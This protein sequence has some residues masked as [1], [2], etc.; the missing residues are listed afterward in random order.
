[1]SL[2]LRSLSLTL[3]GLLLLT[4]AAATAQTPIL[5]P[6]A[7]QRITQPIDDS[8]LTRIT[9]SVHPALAS[10]TDLG[11]VSPSLP[12]QR[13]Q[14]VLQRSSERQAAFDA[15]T[16]SQYAPGS[17]NYHHWLSPDQ[18]GSLFGVSDADLATVTTWLQASGFAVTSISN[19]R[20]FVEFS[21]TA[22]Q[23]QQTFHTQIH[24]FSADGEQHIANISDPQI[25]SALTPVVTG[26]L[27]LN[28]FFARSQMIKGPQVQRSASGKVTRVPSAA[29]TSPLYSDGQGDFYI[30]PFDFATIYNS[31]PLWNSGLNGTGVQIAIVGRSDIFPSDIATF[32]STYGLPNNPPTIIHNGPAPGTSSAG[33]LDENTL[34]VEW[35]GAAAPGA[36]INLV[37]SASTNTSDGGDLSELYIIDNQ[38]A[39]IMSA[40][41]GLCELALGTGGNA[42]FN[43]LWQQAAAEGISVFISSGDQ[44]SAG[45]D[46]N[47]QTTPFGVKFGLA[48]NGIASSPYVT[49][50]GGTDFNDLGNTAAYWNS[51]NAANGSDAKG[52]IPEMPWS[53]SCANP[54]LETAIGGA[55]SFTP[56]ELCNVLAN[57][58]NPNLAFLV[59]NNGGSGG[60]S[61]CTTPSGTTVASCS[62]GYAKP[63]WQVG[64]GVPADGKRDIPD[65]SLFAANGVFGHAYLIEVSGQLEGVGGT[66]V[67]SP[68]MAGLMSLIVQKQGAAQGLANP[69]LYGLAATQNVASCN[70]STVT[71]GNSCIFYDTTYAN[72]VPP[73]VAGTPNCISNSS[74]KYYVGLGILSGYTTTAGYDEAT[75][76]GSVNA[77]NLVNAWH[78]SAPAATTTT[79][80]LTPT[81]LTPISVGTA[82]YQQ[83]TAG[84]G[85][86]PYTYFVSSGTLPS[87]LTLSPNGVLSGTP[88]AV[89]SLSFTITARDSSLNGPFA[90]SQAYSQT[91]LGASTS[92][93][94]WIPARLSTYTGIAI[95]ADVL[96]ATS[97]LPGTFTYTA[98]LYNDGT[99]TP[100]T[101]STVLSA[102][103]YTL[104]ATLGTSGS[105]TIPFTVTPEHIWIVN[106]AGSLGVLDAGGNFNALPSGGGMG[107]G[108][109]N[110]GTVWSGTTAGT[111][112]S[113]FT[114]NGYATT[115]GP[116][117]GGISTPSA[118]AIDGNG[119]I[120]AANANNSVSAVSPLG[121][122]FSPSTG[123]TGGNLSTPSGIA[124]DISGNVWISNSGNN[125]VT[126]ILGGAAPVEPLSTAQ[127]QRNLGA[128]P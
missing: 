16:A 53:D 100:V 116:A 102:G 10:A 76:L 49:A 28:N 8:R 27:S 92:T 52:Y 73:C 62:G 122:A 70:S 72:I 25:P 128:K 54:L 65:V 2:H 127:T 87:W 15:Y 9:G 31:L 12:L 1:M 47:G 35:S 41:Y 126:E 93:I 46:N 108:I 14:L 98:T 119:Y 77:T 103:T 43:S 88:P 57:G 66:S 24:N 20:L 89:S 120:W 95:G 56:T 110:G 106:S 3:S 83:L 109:D 94:S 117:V 40:S 51:S 74:D 64:T 33:D 60:T 90:G 19:S 113:A 80:T 97:T 84:G 85:T 124:I 121:A 48:I 23:V 114:N 82:Y 86:S 104:T 99:I 18:V 61:T 7:R 107:I 26:L 42:F 118:I 45:C 101:S 13:L 21:G 58:S 96:D 30:T 75:G 91:V 34:D 63:S 55:S 36:K 69:T 4:A 115:N 50:I 105:A 37:T 32:Q 29:N 125:S 79:I 5:T 44:L 123:F 67:A 111:S 39:P 22:G 6:P 81:T 112:L 78:T 71:N 68:A 38:V 17:P 59:S 11:A